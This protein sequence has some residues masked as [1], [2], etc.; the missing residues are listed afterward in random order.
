MINYIPFVFMIGLGIPA[1]KMMLKVSCLV[2]KCEKSMSNNDSINK[3]IIALEQTIEKL[4][5]KNDIVNTE[6]INVYKTLIDIQLILDSINN[7]SKDLNG[8]VES[9]ELRNQL[10]R[11]K[12]NS[13]SAAQ[14]CVKVITT[15]FGC[16][17][18]PETANH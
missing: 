5:Q 13:V 3:T 2:E 1:I 4:E 15:C 10:N 12:N 17:K 9:I 18:K 16:K 14:K 7:T 11:E 8:I 6:I